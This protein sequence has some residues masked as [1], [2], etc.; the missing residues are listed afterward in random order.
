MTATAD[1]GCARIRFCSDKSDSS[2]FS[3][4]P[5]GGTSGPQGSAGAM[6]GAVTRESA[7]PSLPCGMST[8]PPG[9]R[10]NG[11]LG[12]GSFVSPSFSPITYPPNARKIVSCSKVRQARLRP[13]TTSLVY[14]VAVKESVVQI[15]ELNVCFDIGAGPPYFSLTSDIVCITH[16]HMDHWP[17]WRITSA[18]GF[19][20]ACS[21]ARFLCRGNRTRR[22]CDAARLAGCGTPGHAVQADPIS[23]GA[24]V[25]SPPRFWHSRL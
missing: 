6:N 22:R 12:R 4:A 15:P 23:A 10:L 18:S 11:F 20:R 21:R 16:S 5:A 14:S 2:P 19:S 3:R 9:A 8:C 13:S 17:G 7:S 24:D 1:P 25:R